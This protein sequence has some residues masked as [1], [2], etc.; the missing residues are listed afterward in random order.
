MRLFDEINFH[1][2]QFFIALAAR[3]HCLQHELLSK[4]F[5]NNK[6]SRASNRAKIKA[7][8]AAFEREDCVCRFGMN[9]L[10][11]ISIV[12]VGDFS[13]L[14]FLF[15][16]FFRDKEFS[17]AHMRESREESERR[18][19]EQNYS[20]VRFHILC[21]GVSRAEI[22]TCVRERHMRGDI[23]QK[24]CFPFLSHCSGAAKFVRWVRNNDA[25][26]TIHYIKIYTHIDGGAGAAAHDEA[27]R[28]EAAAEKV[29]RRLS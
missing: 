15:F 26:H 28:E 29:L 19:R 5:H 2:E 4:T 3:F 13:L 17:S 23:V 7:A 6:R 10:P 18:R 25:E 16:C 12:W 24:I 14:S 20:M 9:G 22:P 8:A 11:K 21:T 1:I 27:A